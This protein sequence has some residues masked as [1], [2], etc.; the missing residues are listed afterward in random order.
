MAA[1][2]LA[3]GVQPSEYPNLTRLEREAFL[4]IIRKR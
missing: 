2:V 4:D 1:F 3:T